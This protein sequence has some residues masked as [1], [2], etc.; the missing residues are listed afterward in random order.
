MR[1]RVT[2]PFEFAV[3]VDGVRHV[4]AED[5]TGSFGIQP[6]HA[7]LTT[8]LAI[9]VVTWRDADAREH[10]V[11]VRGGVLLVSGDVVVVATRDAV[12]GDDLVQLERDVVARFRREE[13]GE[14]TARGGAARLET[15]VIRRIYEYIRGERVRLS[16]GE[17]NGNVGR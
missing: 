7:P 2:T 5:A 4:R 3:D 6:H 10:H 17:E 15:A 11:A 9:S 16:I 14:Q 13:V 8:I 12:I 1:L